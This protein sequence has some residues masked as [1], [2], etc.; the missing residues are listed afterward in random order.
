[1]L[2]EMIMY[3]ANA[4]IKVTSNIFIIQCAEKQKANKYLSDYVVFVKM[5][6]ENNLENDYVFFTK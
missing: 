2:R 5:T 3:N 6:F 1:M 4:Q